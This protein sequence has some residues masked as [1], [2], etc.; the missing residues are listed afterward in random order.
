MKLLADHPS[1]ESEVRRLTR[2]AGYLIRAKCDS[3]R[4]DARAIVDYW[5]KGMQQANST[6]A[7]DSD[8]VRNH[9]SIV[10]TQAKWSAAITSSNTM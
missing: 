9:S 7:D 4:N 1:N 8:K 5:G 3:Q 2:S 6:G 10:K